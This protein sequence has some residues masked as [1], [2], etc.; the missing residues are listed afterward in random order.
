MESLEPKDAEQ[1]GIMLSIQTDIC[2]KHVEVQSMIQV[3]QTCGKIMVLVSLRTGENLLGQIVDVLLLSNCEN[4]VSLFVTHIARVAI[5]MDDKAEIRM[6]W[7]EEE[8]I[9]PVS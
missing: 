3:V 6:V 1:V 5:R 2:A 7:K 4:V 9:S 8:P